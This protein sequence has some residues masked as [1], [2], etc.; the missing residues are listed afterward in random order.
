MD[1]LE[2]VGFHVYYLTPDRK[3]L[4]RVIDDL[5]KPNGTVGTA[6]GKLLY[7][8][9]PGDNKSYVYRIQPDASLADRKQIAPEGSDGMTLDEKGNL[10]LTRSGVHVYSPAG[11]RIAVIKTPERPANVCFGGKDRRTLFITARKGFYSVRM[12]VQGQ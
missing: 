5:V 3:K 8:A 1:G 11:K 12:T 6:D 9:D 4:R 10:Y 7:V 2:Q